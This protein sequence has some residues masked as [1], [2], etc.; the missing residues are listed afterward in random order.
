VIVQTDEPTTLVVRYNEV[1][2]SVEQTAS[3]PKLARTHALILGNLRPSTAAVPFNTDEPSS[4]DHVAAEEVGYDWTID[5]LDASGNPASVTVIDAI[6][7]T[8]HFSLPQG[9][10]ATPEG[11]A[12]T[13]A[14]MRHEHV[15]TSPPVVTVGPD[16]SGSRAVTVDLAASLKQGADMEPAVSRMFV[17]RAFRQGSAGG[18]P[19]LLSVDTGGI[20]SAQPG[21]RVLRGVI[22]TD[23]D[24]GRTLD[25]PNPAQ[26]EFLI[27][28]QF[29]T[30][31]TGAATLSFGV[32][33]TTVLAGDEV[34]VQVEGLVE[35]AGTPAFAGCGGGQICNFVN[36]PVSSE[37]AWS[38]WDFPRTKEANA[39][40]RG[41]AP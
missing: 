29:P 2:S 11:T 26:D 5:A 13:M 16:V 8:G 41:V 25:F 18:A 34:V 24:G 22:V 9:P 1:G 14:Q 12:T 21:T 33:A 3:S 27:V 28:N 4:D 7:S 38:Q 19:Q 40:G 17:V 15:L 35:A 39:Q 10:M 37:R 30:T 36:I 32:S 23:A 6:P 31:T 20:V